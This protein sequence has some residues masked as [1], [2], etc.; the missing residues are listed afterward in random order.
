MEEEELTISD[1]AFIT[2]SLNYTIMKFENYKYPSYEMKRESIA[3]AKA[4]KSKVVAFR[5][6]MQA[7][8]K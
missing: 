2:E 3:E 7:E 5:K 6:R 4:V 1:L 8:K